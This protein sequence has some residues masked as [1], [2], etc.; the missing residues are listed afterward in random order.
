MKNN[1]NGES[2]LS[3]YGDSDGVALMS[4]GGELGVGNVATEEQISI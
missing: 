2:I 3:Q 1:G 4:P